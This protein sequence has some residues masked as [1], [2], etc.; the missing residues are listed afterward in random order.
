MNLNSIKKLLK[1]RDKKAGEDLYIRVLLWAHEKQETGFT[2]E[3][4]KS[5]FS[6]DA[7]QESWIRKIFLT[8]NDQDRKFFEHLRNDDSVTPNRHYYSL[9]EKG[10]T[11]AINYK[12]LAHAEKT[13]NL[14]IWFAVFSILLTAIGI[15]FQIKQTKLTEIQA[16]PEQ[17]NQAR[18]KQS[19]LEF[20][21]QNPKDPNSGLYF[22]DDSGKM[23]TCPEVLRAY[24]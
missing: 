20:C 9:N 15:F 4:L 24:Q 16:I 23:A 14:A 7:L 12:S 10:I 18:S 1:D 8:T 6:L 17:I 2:W 11:A 21:K 19:A 5:N 22:L 13:S 3:S